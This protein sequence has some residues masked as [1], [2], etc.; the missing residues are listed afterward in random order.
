MQVHVH[1]TNEGAEASRLSPV[2]GRQPGSAA[3][4]DIHYHGSQAALGTIGTVPVRPGGAGGGAAFL[5]IHYHGSQAGGLRES[6]AEGGDAEASRISSS[7]LAGNVADRPN[8]ASSLARPGSAAFLD[9]HY[10]GKSISA[11]EVTGRPGLHI[12]DA[13]L[14]DIHYHG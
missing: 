1:D 6:A 14:L 5:D 12:G 9:I 10:H 2:R 13:A 4:L 8:L 7:S 3:F 11:S